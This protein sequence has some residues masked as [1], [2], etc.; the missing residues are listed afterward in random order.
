MLTK[1]AQLVKLAKF[2]L[3]PICIHAATRMPSWKNMILIMCE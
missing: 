2:N 1:N 3:L